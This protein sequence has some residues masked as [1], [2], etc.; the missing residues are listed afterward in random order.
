[1]IN[2]KNYHRTNSVE[3]Y[4]RQNPTYFMLKNEYWNCF[5]SKIVYVFRLSFEQCKQR[6]FDCDYLFQKCAFVEYRA[7]KITQNTSLKAV[8]LNDKR[9]ERLN[10]EFNVMSYADRTNNVVWILS[11]NQRCT[12]LFQTTQNAYG[13]SERF[14]TFRF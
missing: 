2:R 14:K 9:Y 12:V 6:Y 10:C 1:M 4:P 13:P 8:S 11:K 5:T 3:F 7:L